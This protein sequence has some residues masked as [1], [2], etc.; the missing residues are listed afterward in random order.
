MKISAHIFHS[1]IENESRLMKEASS[2]LKLKIV[3]KVLIFGLGKPNLDR[4]SKVN[5]KCVIY[6]SPIIKLPYFVSKI[7][8]FNR[9][10]AVFNFFLF[11][12]YIMFK[13]FSVKPT[14]ISCHNLILLPLSKF[15]KVLTGAYLIYEPHELETE[16]TGLTGKLKIICKWIEKKF[17]YSADKILTVCKPIEDWYCSNYNIDNVYTLR[18]VPSN[19]YLEEKL[20]KSNLLREV[21][22]IPDEHI[23]FIYQGVLDPARG[24]VELVNLFKSTTKNNHL[25]LMGYGSSVE[26]IVDNSDVNIH[27]QPAV[28]VDKII[29]YTSSA[30]LG[31]FFINTEVTLSYQWCL[32]NK[33]FE[34]LIAGLPVIVSD[35][36][37]YLSDIINENQLGWSIPTNSNEL[38]HLVN[39]ISKEDIKKIENK[40]ASYSKLNGWQIEESKLLDLYESFKL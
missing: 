14:Y 23:I 40:V 13:V 32:P 8:F 26:W 3:D 19:P 11:H 15:C 21:F 30:D 2:L 17:I 27:F 24:I 20:I 4:F 10:T 25:V 18:N 35:N 33:F 16:R 38:K 36:L 28:P 6:R 39:S 22:N 31:I 37:T 7:K 12:S 1:P 9:I 29:E 5:D 34:Y